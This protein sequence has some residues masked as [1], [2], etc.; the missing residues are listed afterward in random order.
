MT[1]NITTT[2]LT[3]LRHQPVPASGSARVPGTCGE[4]VQ[5][6]LPGGPDFLIT[7]PVNLW[8]EVHV[9][10]DRTSS[11]ITVMPPG[12]VKTRQAV[13]ATLDRLGRPDLGAR[14]VVASA[15]PEGKGMASST[16]DIVAACRAAASALGQTLT[17]QDISSVARGIEPSDGVMHPGAVCYNHRRCELIEALGPLPPLTVLVVDFGGM[18]D[19][20]YMNR[21]PRSYTLEEMYQIGTAYHLARTGIR[22]GDRRLIGQAATLSALI[23]Q[24]FLLKPLLPALIELAAEHGAHGVCVAHSGT[25]A[26]LLFDG[27][28]TAAAARAGQAVQRQLSP[29]LTTF[30]VESL[31]SW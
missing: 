22:Q 11:A 3:S 24:R 2:N 16:A 6:R 9:A 14:V 5:G 31:N 8:S 25:V 26:G 15:L 19:T 12:K 10:L 4:L 30:A 18:V 28:G 23:N 7:L 21:T 17:P 20:V 27:P 13:R 29:D 1:E